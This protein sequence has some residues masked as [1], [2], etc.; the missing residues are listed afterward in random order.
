M[1]R[2]LALSGPYADFARDLRD[3]RAEKGLTFRQLA[4]TTHYS[5]STLAESASGRRLPTLELTLAIVKACGGDMGEWR[6]RWTRLREELDRAED[7]Q[8]LPGGPPRAGIHPRGARG[9]AARSPAEVR[10]VLRRPGAL[11]ER[12]AC[13]EHH[14]QH[15]DRPD[16]A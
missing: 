13:Q 10:A 2:P 11:V 12:P 9:G 1:A 14:Q 3:L 4:A 6:E 7:D 5:A 8:A 16:H 15:A